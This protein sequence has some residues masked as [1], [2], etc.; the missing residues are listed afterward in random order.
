LIVL[1]NRGAATRMGGDSTT[2]AWRGFVPAGIGPIRIGEADLSSEAIAFR[3]DSIMVFAP[4]APGEKQIALEYA[5]RPGA[6]LR[7]RFPQD[8][9]ATNI[10]T[11]DPQ[12]RIDGGDMAAV[13]SQLIEGE[14]FHR[15]VGAPHAGDEIRVN[16]GGTGGKVPGWLLPG[17]VGL[18]GAGLL[19]A[20]FRVRPRKAT[21]SLET[22]TDRI[23]EL[24]ARYGGR[25]GE[26]SPEEWTRYQGELTQLRAELSA[27]LAS[28]KPPT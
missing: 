1:V 9:V 20:L 12:A 27:H 13:D 23:A 25:E 22:L 7:L 8:S 15:W 26:V 28:R 16:F 11:Q 10:L 14:S 4:I 2:P 19:L 3:G 17:M 24:E 6:T 18:A 5:I 21:A